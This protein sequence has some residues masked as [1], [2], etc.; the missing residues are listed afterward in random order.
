MEDAARKVERTLRK[1]AIAMLLQPHI[2]E[3]FD[4][5]VTGVKSSGTFARL[6]NPPADGMIVRGGT[7][8]DVG[9]KINVRLLSVEPEQGFIDLERI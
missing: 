5:I 2:G 3:R 1:A 7:G 9:D 4:A 8:V 6:L